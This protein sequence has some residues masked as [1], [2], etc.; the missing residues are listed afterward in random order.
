MPCAYP[1][2]GLTRAS[3]KYCPFLS[4]LTNYKQWQEFLDNMRVVKKSR[5]W[6][7]Q[8]CRHIYVYI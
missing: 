7:I 2:H 6:K 4:N 8:V 3:P 5:L 1:Y